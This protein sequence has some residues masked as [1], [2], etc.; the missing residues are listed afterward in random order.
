MKEYTIKCKLTFT[1]EV[2]GTASNNPDIHGTFIASKAPDAKTAEEEIA[3]IGAEDYEKMQMTVFPRNADGQPILYDYQI[4]GFFKDSCK[5][6]RKVDGTKSKTIK[7]YKQEID[8]LLFVN[9]RM[10]PIQMSG[11]MGDCQRPLRASTPMGERVAL[12]HSEAVP[13]GSSIEIEIVCLTKD[14]YELAKE[15]LDY[16]KLRGIGQWRNSGKGRFLFEEI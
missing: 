12:A 2:L 9:P 16:G 13:A 6:L 10:I 4:K 15:C 7:A 3:A 11:E 8:G 5:A 14:M 1:E